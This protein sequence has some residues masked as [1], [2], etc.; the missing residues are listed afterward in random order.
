MFLSND[1]L[2]SWPNV[3]PRTQSLLSHLP[4]FLPVCLEKTLE[5]PLDC[6]AIQLVNSKGNQFWIFIGRMNAEAETPILWPPDSKSWLIGKDPDTGK[7]WRQERRG[8]Q[9]M[10]W[11]DDITDSMDMTLSKLREPVMDRD[12][13]RV[14]VHGVAKSGTQLNELNW[15]EG[16]EMAFEEGKPVCAMWEHGGGMEEAESV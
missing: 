7:D 5:S 10:R 14:A 16:R 2:F 1:L 8:W 12:A 3:C 9:R 15:T 6:K 4:L 11:L 13:W